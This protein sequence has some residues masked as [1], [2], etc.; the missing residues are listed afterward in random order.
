MITIYQERKESLKEQAGE[1][2]D[3]IKT[4]IKSSRSQQEDDRIYRRSGSNQ[5][6]AVVLTKR[7]R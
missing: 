1:Y 7:S 5:T 2:K 3:M 4:Y 6:G